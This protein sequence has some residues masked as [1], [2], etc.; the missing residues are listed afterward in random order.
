MTGQNIVVESSAVNE[1]K[2]LS[3]TATAMTT[4]ED[5]KRSGGGNQHK[6]IGE[7]AGGTVAECAM[8]CCCC[9]CT[10]LHFLLLA[11]YKVPTGLCRKAW[12]SKKQKK[13]LKKKNNINNP[14]VYYTDDDRVYFDGGGNVNGGSSETTEFETE[15]WHRFYDGAG[16]GRSSSQKELQ[17]EQQQ[18]Q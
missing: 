8:V 13:V 1:R 14:G 7:V 6:R 2:E 15:M 9:P 10:V 4:K 17:E 18:H 16:F 11:L 3:R 5:E 12:R